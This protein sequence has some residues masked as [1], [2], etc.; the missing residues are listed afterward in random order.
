MGNYVICSARVLI[1]LQMSLA[2][3]AANKRVSSNANWPFFRTA[4]LH[5]RERISESGD[6][7]ASREGESPDRGA[8]QHETHSALGNRGTVRIEKINMGDG[9]LVAATI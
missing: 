6:D 5:F 2:C 8:E 1:G 9:I 3:A 4:S 7:E